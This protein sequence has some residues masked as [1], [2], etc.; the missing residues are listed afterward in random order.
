QTDNA[1]IKDSCID[2]M[3]AINETIIANEALSTDPS[4]GLSIYFP[5]LKCQYDQSLWRGGGN[6][7][8]NKIPSSY[9]DLYLSQ[10]GL[11]DD[12]L[13]AYLGISR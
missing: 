1:E 12:F 9:S 5:K 7:E 13:E 8:F 11:W 10:D 3:D 4:Y 6:P 2:L